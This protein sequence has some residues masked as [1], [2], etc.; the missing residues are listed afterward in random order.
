VAKRV[1]TEVVAYEKRI[2]S[3][4]VKRIEACLS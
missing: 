2:P 1:G 3:A 4:E